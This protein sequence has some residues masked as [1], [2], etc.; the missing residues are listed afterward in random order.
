MCHRVCVLWWWNEWTGSATIKCTYAANEM[1]ILYIVKR[2]A[3]ICVSISHCKPIQFIWSFSNQ[4]DISRNTLE[5]AHTHTY[6]H[7]H[8]YTFTHTCTKTRTDTVLYGVSKEKPVIRWSRVWHCHCTEHIEC[9]EKKC[10]YLRMLFYMRILFL[11]IYTCMLL[12]FVQIHKHIDIYSVGKCINN[13][14]HKYIYY[15]LARVLT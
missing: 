8:T 15:S 4:I 6:R 5:R 9:R 1:N 2:N 12:L 14:I 10:T 11:F 13:D 3:Y 7:I